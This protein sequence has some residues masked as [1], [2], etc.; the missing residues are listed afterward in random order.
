MAELSIS[1][2]AERTGLSIHTLRYYERADLI[3][4][5]RRGANGHRCYTETDVAWLEFLQ[6]LRAT[7]MPTSQMRHFAEL[8]RQGNASL[9][10]RVAMLEG[11]HAAVEARIAELNDNLQAIRG[12]L[13][14]LRDTAPEREEA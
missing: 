14:C 10:E 3:T 1:Q 4:G 11:H 9:E 2:V 6:R 8:R 7:G 12:K 5:V 13:L